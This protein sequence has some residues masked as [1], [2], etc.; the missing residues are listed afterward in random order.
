VS[1]SSGYL[2][3]LDGW[4]GLAVLGVILGHAELVWRGM[5][6]LPPW[7]RYLIN[8]SS[9]K[10]VQ[11]FFAISGFLITS[12]LIE[13]WHSFGRISLKRFYVR[14]A[15]RIL[16]PAITYLA[17]LGILGMA[18]IAALPRGSILSCLLFF[19]NYWSGQCSLTGHFWSLS[20]EEQFYLVWPS[21]LVLTGLRR[22]KYAAAAIILAIVAWRWAAF[23]HPRARAL[24]PGS[25]WGGS[26]ICFDGLLAGCLVG[27][28]LDSQQLKKLFSKYLSA[29]VV[30][31]I[32]LLILAT[33]GRTYT[34]GGRTIQSALMPFL[35]VATVLNPQTSL[36]R[37]LENRSLRWIGR[38]SYSLYIWQ[39]IF[40]FLGEKQLAWYP[41][42]LLGLLG[43]ATLS[44]YF[45]ERP[46]VKLGYS[47]AP[48]P[49][50]GH[51]DLISKPES[52]SV[53]F[54]FSQSSEGP[55]QTIPEIPRVPRIAL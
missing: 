12:R 25:F 34:P 49:S 33:G 14:R 55:A 38:L 45:V 35:V 23:Y 9:T 15:C 19:R 27:I 40:L 5:G 17:I 44:F 32:I 22:S 8:G 3:T 24:L 6:V 26:D 21:I 20:I 52:R 10:G 13:E 30:G 11:L 18:G 51:A 50:L 41:L 39:E 4:R 47:L 28:L 29:W 1:K 2:P 16:P 54:G 53:A 48:P 37:L 36:G 43:V 42:R 31:A 7:A 46:M